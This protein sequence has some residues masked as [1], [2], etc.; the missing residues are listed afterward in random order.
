[1]TNTPNWDEATS[2]AD[3]VSLKTDVEKVLVLTN[4]RLEKRTADSPIAPNEVEFI[5]EVVE[6][7]NKPVEEKQFTTTS[8]RLKKKLRDI[9]E[10]KDPTEKVKLSILKVGEQFNTQYSVK[11]IKD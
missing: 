9:F 8:K 6:E 5:A 2:S 7:D 10:N 1:M 4:Y 11:E 3:Y